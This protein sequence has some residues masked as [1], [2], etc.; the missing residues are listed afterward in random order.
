[1]LQR[2]KKHAQK[3]CLWWFGQW[4]DESIVR[5]L[6]IKQQL[7]SLYLIQ[8][9]RGPHFVQS[10]NPLPAFHF[11]LKVYWELWNPAQGQNQIGQQWMHLTHKSHFT[12]YDHQRHRQNHLNSAEHDNKPSMPKTVVLTLIQ[13]GTLTV[14][15]ETVATT[16]RFGRTSL[17][18]PVKIRLA[19]NSC[20]WP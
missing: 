15:I 3:Q 19:I 11:T 17:H 5:C 12:V 10:C 20:G 6:K 18:F 8:L 13:R 9:I 1:M 7:A 4:I 2:E 14:Q 16:W